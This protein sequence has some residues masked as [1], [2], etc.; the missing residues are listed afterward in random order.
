MGGFESIISAC[1]TAHLRMADQ[2]E[3]QRAAHDVAGQ[4]RPQVMPEHFRPCEATDEHQVEHLA[5]EPI[6]C[7]SPAAAINHV[8]PMMIHIRADSAAG[9]NHT[10]VAMI[11]PPATAFTNISGTGYDINV[12]PSAAIAPSSFDANSGSFAT[13]NANSVMPARL[14]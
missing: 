5:P 11:H 9:I 8:R 2:G 14:A 6:T 1:I 13:A 7:T 3:Y 4:H 10:I 12:V